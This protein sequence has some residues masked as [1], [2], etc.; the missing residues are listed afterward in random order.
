MKRSNTIV[1]ASAGTSCLLQFVYPFVQYMGSSNGI[2]AVCASV[3]RTV[4]E[5]V[6]IV[7]VLPYVPDDCSDADG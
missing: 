3:A 1:L 4:A 6:T 2:R 7:R 5:N